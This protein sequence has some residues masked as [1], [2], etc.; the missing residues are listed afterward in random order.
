MNLA[1]IP[2][3]AG[4]KRI[5]NKN[6]IGFCGRPMIAYA[7]DCARDSGLFDKI[8]VSTDSQQIADLV[9]DLG[10]PV[11]FLRKAELADD[12]THVTPVMHWVV[13][14]YQNAG[15]SV[16]TVCL[17]LPCSPLIEPS[18]LRAAHA[19]FLDQP[20]GVPVLAVVPYTYP[21]QRALAEQEPGLLRPAFPDSWPARSQDL[22]ANFHDA[23]SF[24]F[25][26]ANYLMQCDNIL[27]DQFRPHLL[28]RHKAVDI[29]DPEDLEFAEI[30]YRGVRARREALGAQAS[31]R[32]RS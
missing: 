24:C 12:K 22:T 16:D 26:G 14:Q 31:T 8:H 6:T 5:K 20:G 30:V 28:P 17:L 13:E 2:A 3:R 21:V 9:A 18:D 4:S 7:L 1:I 15:H 10:F 27:G 23:G 19:H 29:D 25:I 32:K 11:D